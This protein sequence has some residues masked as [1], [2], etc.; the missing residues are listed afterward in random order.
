M[1][2]IAD[3]LV[4]T[5][6]QELGD[7]GFFRLVEAHAGIRLYIPENP[8]RSELPATIG[9]EAAGRLSKLYPCGY[10]K[11][12]LAREFRAKRYREAGMSNSQIARRLGLTETGVELLFK[13]LGK[14]QPVTKRR[15]DSRQMDLFGKPAHHD[16]H[17]PN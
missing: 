1:P 10:I 2:A 15:K 5:L 3:E 16:G 12:P 4:E 7:D 13:R 11:I 14:R 17:D 6:L 8:A 9:D